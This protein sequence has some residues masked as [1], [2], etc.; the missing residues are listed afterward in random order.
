MTE[1]RRLDLDRFRSE[2]PI[3]ERWTYLNHAAIGPMTRSGAERMAA[4]ARRVAETGDRHWP[5]RA[6]ET[7]R[8]RAQAAR[9]LGARAP[10]EVAFVGNTSEGLSAVAWGVDWRAG[11]NVVGPEPEFPANVYP[12]LSLAPLG[13]EYRRVPEREGRVEAADLVAAM[14]ERTRLVAVS[15]VQY[16]S[17]HRI[18][19]APLAAA[20]RDAGAL[21]VLDA[22]QGVGALALDVEAA[23]VDVCAVASHK[24]LLGPEGLGV[25]WVSDR[26]IERLRSTRHGWRSVAGRFDWTGIDPTPAEGAL[27]FE[28][29]TLNFAGVHALGAGLDLLLALGPERVEERVLA[30]ADRVA[31][32]LADRGFRL[33]EPRR[34]SG[35]TSGIV[36]GT[37]PE[38]GSKELVDALAERSVVVSHRAGRLRVAPHGYNTEEEV[39]RL[40]AG[41]DELL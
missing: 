31:R 38:R 17:G 15:W 6:E 32:G 37:H 14:D 20:C 41:L 9:L 5:E 2:L 33:A 10:H 4:L 36:A 7:E 22:I 13:V 24:W 1:L 35:E 26:V 21:L 34:A 30:L 25:L 18:D 12:W 39:G 11:D 28:A 19:L 23:G 40:L 8:V 16:A 27:R 29:G 3:T